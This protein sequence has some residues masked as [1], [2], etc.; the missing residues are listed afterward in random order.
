MTAFGEQLPKDDISF[1]LP[2]NSLG[3]SI[4]IYFIKSAFGTGVIS[5]NLNTLGIYYIETLARNQDMR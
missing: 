2:S 4:L 3:F 1:A 5:L